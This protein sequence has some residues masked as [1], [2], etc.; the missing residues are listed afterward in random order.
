MFHRFD[1]PSKKVVFERASA[2]L[3][4]LY[5]QI[6]W[7]TTRIVC[8]ARHS[9]M[10]VELNLNGGSSFHLTPARTE[11]GANPMLGSEQ[12]SSSISHPKMY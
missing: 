12:P 7:V 2:C 3:N 4:N 10:F 11:F 8:S 5:Q 1:F 6:G 9:E